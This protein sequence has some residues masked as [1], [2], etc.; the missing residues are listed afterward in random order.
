M[1]QCTRS[2]GIT[3]EWELLYLADTPCNASLN[4]QRRAKGT[5]PED[6]IVDATKV[7][8]GLGQSWSIF[9]ACNAA[10]SET[11]GGLKEHAETRKRRADRFRHNGSPD[12]EW[13][14]EGDSSPGDRRS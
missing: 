14:G 12:C 8:F 7:S 6:E 2:I 9:T 1:A 5:V 11:I 3:F 10:V 13:D 4:M